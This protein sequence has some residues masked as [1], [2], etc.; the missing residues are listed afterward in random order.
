MLFSKRT[1]YALL[2]YMLVVTLI[3]I[4]RPGLMFTSGGNVKAF[5]LGNEKTIFSLGIFCAVTAI[6]C[7]YFFTLIDVIFERVLV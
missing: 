4:S 7:S 1:I 3:I 5:G 2:F 6:M